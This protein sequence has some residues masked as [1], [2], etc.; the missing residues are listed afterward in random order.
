VRLPASKV[1]FSSGT[2]AVTAKSLPLTPVPAGAVTEIVPVAAPVGTLTVM[3]ESSV[4]VKLP[5]LVPLNVTPLVPVKLLPV[6]TIGVPAWPL[7]GLNDAITG[8]FGGAIVTVKF[9]VPRELL[10]PVPPGV[11]TAITP[12]VAA[13]GTVTVIWFALLIVNTLAAVPLKVTREAAVKF[14]P[15]IITDCPP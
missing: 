12:V 7:L 3:C 4:T 8:G 6:I 14:V 1:M 2:E 15:L 5:A 10:F 13:A 11:V 9:G